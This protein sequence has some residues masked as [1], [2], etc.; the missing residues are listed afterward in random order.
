MAFTSGGLRENVFVVRLDGTGYRQL[1]DDGFRNRGPGLVGG[2]QRDRVLL[3]SLG[4]LTR[5]GR[6]GPTAAA[7]TPLDARPRR[8]AQ[9]YPEWSPDGQPASRPRACR[10]RAVVDP[11]KPL[12]ERVVLELHAA[13]GR[14]ESSTG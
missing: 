8:E 1:T 11:A 2:R 14:G 4:P 3:R 13:A 9:W 6:C 12:G 7:S 5:S 10:R